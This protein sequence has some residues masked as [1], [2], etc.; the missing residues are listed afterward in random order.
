MASRMESLRD[1][2][3][4]RIDARQIRTLMEITGNAGKSQVVEVVR[5]AVKSGNNML[6]V[7]G[8]EW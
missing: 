4:I 6:D 8:S 2:I 7:Q 3:R 1:L 5:A